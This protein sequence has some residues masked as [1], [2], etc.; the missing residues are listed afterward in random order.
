MPNQT[1]INHGD[2][3]QDCSGLFV[4]LFIMF[5]DIFKAG[6]DDLKS[7]GTKYSVY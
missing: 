6:V 3:E 4:T 5:A 7:R 2:Q 1:R